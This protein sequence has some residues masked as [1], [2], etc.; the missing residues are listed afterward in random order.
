[1]NEEEV[2]K[3]VKQSAKKRFFALINS[4]TGVLAVIAGL[5]GVFSSAYLTGYNEPRRVVLYEKVA[6]QHRISLMEAISDINQAISEIGIDNIPQES[7][8]KIASAIGKI[9][10]VEKG[11]AGSEDDEK[12]IFFPKLG[13]LLAT[14][15]YAMDA[16]VKADAKEDFRQSVALAILVAITIFWVLCLTIYLFSN[17]EKKVTFSMSM[18]QTVL[19][20]YVGVFTGLMGLPTIG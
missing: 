6:E 7:Q 11:L 13:K 16:P 12:G 19:G 5:F 3:L 17:D 14:N 1:M 8:Q 9:S 4:A 2:Q 10:A 15:A 20:F 18:I